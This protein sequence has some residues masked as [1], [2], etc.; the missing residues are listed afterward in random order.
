[1]HENENALT[2][3]STAVSQGVQPIRL[4]QDVVA[5]RKGVE[6]SWRQCGGRWN[7]D[8][9]RGEKKR[10]FGGIDYRLTIMARRGLCAKMA[11][12]RS[13]SMIP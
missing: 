12:W 3:L 6:A 8:L 5:E 9:M 7:G 11:H 1:M 13:S 2:G 10:S 4:M